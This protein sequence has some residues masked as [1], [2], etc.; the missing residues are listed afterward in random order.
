VKFHRTLHHAH[1]V[2][3]E[4]GGIDG[5]SQRDLESRIRGRQIGQRLAATVDGRLVAN[6]RAFDIEIQHLDV[7]LVDDRLIC[8]LQARYA[9]A[10][11][12]QLRTSSAA[13]RDHHVTARR[14]KVADKTGKGALT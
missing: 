12:R 6:R 13:E 5:Q 9:A 10:Y 14:T 7:V 8:R 1:P 4:T 3:V 11:L 2:V